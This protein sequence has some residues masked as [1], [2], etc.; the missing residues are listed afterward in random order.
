M[1]NV[2]M[3]TVCV[4]QVSKVMEE[5][6]TQVRH[7]SIY[8][9]CMTSSILLIG[10]ESKMICGQSKSNQIRAMEMVVC[11]DDM[12]KT[13]KQIFTKYIRKIL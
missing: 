11:N 3:V 4:T 8:C 1:P 2:S 5:L 10:V 13:R 12:N 9:L 7:H 6:V